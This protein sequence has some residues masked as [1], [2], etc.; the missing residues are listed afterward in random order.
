MNSRLNDS[1]DRK[2]PAYA[3]AAAALF[4]ASMPL[5]KILLGRLEPILLAALLYLGSGVGLSLWLIFRRSFSDH[6]SR[7]E[8]GLKGSDIPWLGSAIFSGGVVGPILLLIGLRLTPASSAA[9]LLNLE[10]VFTA[11]LAWFVF[12]ENFDLRIALGMAA[13]IAGGVLLSWAGRPE[14]GVPWGAIAIAGACLAWAIDNN[15]TRNVASGDPLQIAAAKGLVAGVVNLIIAFSL[16]AVMPRAIAIGEAG[17]VGFLSYGVSLTLFVLALRLIGAARTGAYFSTAPFVGALLSSL[18]LHDKL[19]IYFLVAAVLMIIGLWLH[20][21]E[22]HEHVHVHEA[23]EHEH[24]HSHDEHHH[25]HR[26][27]ELLAQTHT[28]LH[29][30]KRLRHSHPHYPD[31]HHRHDH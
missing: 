9:L 25:H 21:T 31:T 8:A 3:L 19:T 16:G 20:L 18:V 29:Q 22:R 27:P 30:H 10:A 12:K 17:L 2:G 13:I 11:V 6:L 23:I 14:P 24:R 1:N 28:H 4:G 26:E 7:K 15:L 5:A